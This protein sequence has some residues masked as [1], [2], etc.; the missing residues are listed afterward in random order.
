[1]A[2]AEAERVTRV[3]LAEAE[4]I[5]KQVQASGG[6]RY[7][8]SRQIADRFAEA[9]EKSGVDIVPRIAIGGGSSGAGGG[10]VMQ[11]LL[12]VLLAEKTGENTTALTAD[13]VKG[14]DS[15]VAA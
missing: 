3:G 4:A 7:Q 9:L 5:A 10:N 1:M 15:G 13:Q 6:A 14:A 8:L 11:A 12:A 2:N